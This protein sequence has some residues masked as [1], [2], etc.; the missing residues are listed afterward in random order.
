MLCKFS[1]QQYIVTSVTNEANSRQD[2]NRISLSLYTNNRYQNNS[3][4][5]YF[6]HRCCTVLQQMANNQMTPGHSCYVVIRKVL[7]ANTDNQYNI[8]SWTNQRHCNNESNDILERKCR[9]HNKHINS[10]KYHPY[11]SNWH[12]I[13]VG[14][15]YFCPVCGFEIGLI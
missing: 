12:Y 11:Y 2:C 8:S 1:S 5:Q 15:S 14:V 3:K 4:W 6:P 13:F 7:N 10:F 9:Q